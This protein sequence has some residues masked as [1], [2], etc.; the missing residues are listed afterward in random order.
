MVKMTQ[1]VYVN[2][3]FVPAS[4]AKIS[5]FDRGFLFADGIYE[6]SPILRGKIVDNAP[7]LKRLE[8]SAKEL[9]LPLP[10]SLA[11][12]E[13]IQHQLVE[14]NNVQEGALYLQV[15]RGAADRDFAFPK[16]P[17]PSLVMFIQ[18][19]ALEKADNAVKGISV[20]SSPDIRWG[21]RDIKTTQLLAAS[22][23]KQAAIEAG[24]QDTWMV[25]EGFVTEG[26]SNNAYI[27]TEDDVIVTRHIGNDILSGITRKVVLQLAEEN[28]YKIE[29]RPFSLEE[30][31]A[32][33]EAFVTSATTFVWPVKEIDGHKI[34]GG[35]P[36]PLARRLRELYVEAALG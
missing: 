29:E 13:A 3:E 10:M 4:E 17:K 1:I 19:K 15:T 33:K 20:I 9:A 27:V 11:D 6:V 21:R 23:A 31:Y 14:K 35:Q 5:V 24:A 28:G 32:A 16:E 25:Q 26:S 36:G 18:E 12:I 22:M 8:R 7:H 30:A 2:G 34:G